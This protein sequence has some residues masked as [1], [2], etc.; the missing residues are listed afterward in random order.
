V[1]SASRSI[2]PTLG[3]IRIVSDA[4]LF[5]IITLARISLTQRVGAHRSNSWGA[6]MHLWKRNVYLLLMCLQ[7]HT[8]KEIPHTL[9]C[10]RSTTFVRAVCTALHHFFGKRKTKGVFCVECVSYA[11]ARPLL[12]LHPPSRAKNVKSL[13]N[14]MMM[15]TLQKQQQQQTLGPLIAPVACANLI[16]SRR[17]Y[18]FQ[19]QRTRR[20]Y[21]SERG[22]MSSQKGVFID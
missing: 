16:N 13:H 20:N 2:P 18:Q 21:G 1:R 9:C 3:E 5:A 8:R 19:D 6:C 12:L 22:E 17:Q 7:R 11:L 10:A 4:V 15:E 14:L